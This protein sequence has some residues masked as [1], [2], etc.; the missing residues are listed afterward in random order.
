[1]LL[2]IAETRRIYFLTIVIV[3]QQELLT[4]DEARDDNDRTRENT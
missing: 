4:R 1:M 3:F 2:L